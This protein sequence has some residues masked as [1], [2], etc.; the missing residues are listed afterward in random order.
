MTTTDT[1]A[2]PDDDTPELAE[3][4]Q[5]LTQLSENV[6][7]LD[8]RLDDVVRK[9]EALEQREHNPWPEASKELRDWVKSELNPTFHMDALLKEWWT[10][11][12]VMSELTALYEAYREMKDSKATGWDKVAWHKI[13]AETE[14]RIR[15]HIKR[16]S[17]PAAGW[18][19]R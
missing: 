14:E 18:D 19:S 17:G 2:D 7:E 5:L 12:A 15:V 16:S 11:N 13:R 1:P 4:L 3:V 8:Q 9:V 10:N 6:E